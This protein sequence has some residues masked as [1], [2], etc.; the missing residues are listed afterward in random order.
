MHT[1]PRRALGAA[2]A[3]TL[4]AGTLAGCSATSSNSSSA[5]SGD[6]AQSNVA[7]DDYTP[8]V[9][10]GT[11]VVVDNL[12]W[13]VRGARSAQ[14]LGASN[15]FAKQDAKGT[16]VVVSVSVKNG[17]AETANI[18]SGMI[19]LVANG[20]EYET[21]SKGE[22]ALIATDS[23]DPF[24]FEDLGPDLT[25]DGTAVFDIPTSALRPAPEVCFGE[26]GFG[27]S[28]GCIALNRMP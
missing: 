13:R 6:S 26:M 21:D 20:R 8:H 19:K 18:T 22:L 12:T 17:N 27:P 1:T 7:T 24:V 10:Q 11:P 4:L 25:Q 15:E 16:F 14:V 28:R 23:G 5:G 3:L 9:K 2:A